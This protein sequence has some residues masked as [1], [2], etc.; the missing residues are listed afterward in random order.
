MSEQRAIPTSKVTTLTQSASSASLPPGRSLTS[1]SG[2]KACMALLFRKSCRASNGTVAN[3]GATYKG[4][5]VAEPGCF[6]LQ[7]PGAFF[8]PDPQNRPLRAASAGQSPLQ[9]LGCHGDG[10]NP[11]FRLKCSPVQLPRISSSDV[12]RAPLQGAPP[13]LAPIPQSN[14][15]GTSKNGGETAV[16]KIPKS[17]SGL[18]R[19]KG[20]AMPKQSALLS[21]CLGNIRTKPLGR[22]RPSFSSVPWP[23]L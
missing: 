2:A 22:L 9:C 8:D 15:I 16:V 23:A 21:V 20:Q 6:E 11:S 14:C 12:L 10:W 19:N 1:M 18:A 13:P 4:V 5:D 7:G 17:H 3:R